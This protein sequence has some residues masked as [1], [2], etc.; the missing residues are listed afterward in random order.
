MSEAM[1]AYSAA[2]KAVA[3]NPM[4]PKE[5]MDK[6]QEEIKY[7]E[8]IQM[9]GISEPKLEDEDKY[10]RYIKNIELTVL[11][12]NN[13]SDKYYN[14]INTIKNSI[15]GAVTNLY[16]QYLDLE[17]N[18]ILQKD[19]LNYHVRNF[20]DIKSKYD[21]GLVSK[22]DYLKAKDN[23]DIQNKNYEKL[24]LNFENLEYALK[25]QIGLKVKSDVDFLS[26]VSID[27]D[28]SL[29][30][31][32]DY[33]QGAKESSFDLK[34]INTDLSYKE[35]EL[36]LYDKYINTNSRERQNLVANISIDKA[37]KISIEGNIESN[38]RYALEDIMLKRVELDESIS[39]LEINKIKYLQA[40][41][42]LE[43]GIINNTSLMALESSY[44]GSYISNKVSERKV[45]N[46]LIKFE[47]L[48]EKGVKY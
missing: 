30:N 32:K 23:L 6:L 3:T 48:I 31:V 44:I 12:A 22:L 36:E 4:M 17:Q 47:L 8:Y 41:K 40:K 10:N 2:L 34:N 21:K 27:K 35:K 16:L 25:N 45:Y 7:G 28:Y 43:L 38:V 1:T 39:A 42:Q 9:F 24:R 37:S 14:N 15:E 29:I 46:S 20:E 18:M 33:I 26:N 11:N 19:F 13:Q 5:K